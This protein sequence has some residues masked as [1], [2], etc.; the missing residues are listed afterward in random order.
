MSRAVSSVVLLCGLVLGAAAVAVAA[1]GDLDL[2]FGAGGTVSTDLGDSDSPGAVALQPDGKIVVAGIRIIGPPVVPRVGIALVRYR[3]DGTL[4]EGFGS[5]GLVV[6]ELDD[7][8]FAVLAAVA[9]QPDGKI[10]VAGS[11]GPF[12]GDFRAFLLARYHSDGTLDASFGSGGLVGT[13]FGHRHF[14]AV[15]VVALRSDGRILVAG[16]V[17]SDASTQVA[18]ARYTSDGVLDPTFGVGGT[19]ASDFGESRFMR[20]MAFQPD[21]KIVL[22]ASPNSLEAHVFLV[23]RYTADGLLDTAFGQGGTVVTE[24]GGYTESSDLGVM[25]DGRIVVAGGSGGNLALARYLSDGRPDPSFGAAG[26]V[27]TDLGGLEAIIALALQPDG[28]IV[29]TG[30]VA[31]PFDLAA[32]DLIAI[33]GVLYGLARYTASGELDASFGTGGGRGLDFLPSLVAQQPDGRILAVGHAYSDIVV[34]RVIGDSSTT[35]TGEGQVTSPPGDVRSA[36]G[37]PSVTAPAR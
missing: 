5:G 1:P 6:T 8:T 30:N 29:V 17:S 21:G 32:A 19:V 10:V 35:P 33:R 24:F 2:T 20:A 4:D 36:A 22:T 18:L 31:I 27:T 7:G 23:A 15:S 16:S 37:R 9:V 11:A 13:G 26:V 3:S 12:S 28:K 34:A 25:P 14:A